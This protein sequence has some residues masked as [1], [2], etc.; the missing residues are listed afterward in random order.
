MKKLIKSLAL[1][2]LILPCALLFTA[3]DKEPPETKYFQRRVQYTYVG[4][5]TVEWENEEVRNE[6][7]A[8][9]PNYYNEEAFIDRHISITQGS[10]FVFDTDGTGGT[11]RAGGGFTYE[12]K[13]KNL[14]LTFIESQRVLHFTIDGGLTRRIPFSEMGLPSNSYFLAVYYS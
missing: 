2:L 12:I 10:Y 3:C 7:L 13:D 5:I 4:R 14:T 8:S 6:I 9:S 1:V 11:G